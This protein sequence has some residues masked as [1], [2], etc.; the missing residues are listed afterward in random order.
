MITF[1][2]FAR[3]AILKMMGKKIL[4]K[5]TIR[6]IIENDIANNN[7]RRLFARVMVTKCGSRYHASLT[8]PQGSGI[9][10]SMAR[11]NGLAVIPESSQGVKAGDVVEVQMLEWGE[12][13]GEVKTLPIV[14]IVGKSQSGKTLLME[15]LIA[16]FKKRGYK[17]AAV[18]HSHS[19]MEIDHPGKDS[20]KFAQ[21]GSDAVCISSPDKLAF[22][23]NL[24]HELNIEEIMPILGSEFDLVLIEGFRKSKI[25]KIEVHRKEL[26]DDLLC[27]PKELSAIVTDGSLDTLI[28]NSC[29]LS[30]F[31]WSD[32]VAVADFIEKNFLRT[33]SGE[34]RCL[35]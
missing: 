33:V 2:Q 32:T 4:A 11:A 10:T 18:K 7:G 16:E 31:R 17:V 27:S 22:I 20:W 5:P 15:Q 28:A 21:A 25:P 34:G 29:K 19:G 9:L 1:E 8:G 3:P 35:P 26:G 24:D 12:E 6:A 14:S 13:Q 23:K 30:A